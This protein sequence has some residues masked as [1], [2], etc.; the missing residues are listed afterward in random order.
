MPDRQCELKNFNDMRKSKSQRFSGCVAYNRTPG[1]TLKISDLPYDWRIG[2]YPDALMIRLMR[3]PDLM[4]AQHWV[5]LLT[6]AGIACHL[7]NRYIQG[8]AGEIPVDQ[9][10]PDIWLENESDRTTAMHIIE[11]PVNHTGFE[12]RRNW[13]CDDC[14]EWLESQFT[15]CWQCGASRPPRDS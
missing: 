1:K 14:G 12:T 2:D 5:N 8:G 7:T 13:H 10:G 4:L 3:A 9:C 11:G 6:Q 15:A